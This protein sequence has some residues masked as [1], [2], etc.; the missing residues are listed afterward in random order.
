MEIIGLA[1]AGGLGAL[2]KDIIKDNKL[3]LPRFKKGNVWLGC[4]GGVIVGMCVGYLVDQNPT[5]AF[6]SGYAGTQILEGL[7][8]KNGKV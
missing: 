3:I 7:I 1:C 6:F 8:E 4:V 5:T 2:V